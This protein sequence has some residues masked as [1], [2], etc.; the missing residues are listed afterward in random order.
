MKKKFKYLFFG[1]LL[2]LFIPKVYAFTYDIN[3]TTKNTSV[4]KGSVSEIKV[5]LDN[6]KGDNKGIVVCE[7]KISFNGDIALDSKVRTLNSWTMTAGKKYLFET[8]DFV[9]DNSDMFVIPVKVNGNGS[10]K[11]F[12]IACSDAVVEAK[13]DDN[14]MEFTVLSENNNTTGNN[15]ASNNNGTTGN[16]ENNNK[17]EETKSSNANLSNITLNEGIIE[18]DPN[19]TEYEIEVKDFSKLEVTPVAESDKA[20]IMVDKN[21]LENSNSIVLTVTAENGD[22]KV[23]TIRVK[24]VS[25]TVNSNNDNTTNDSKDNKYIP[26]FIVIICILVIINIIRIVLRKKKTI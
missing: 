20:Q 2:I 16:K 18:F 11:I 26:I 5:S 14:E 12:D 17:V 1:I 21:I 4:K 25:S 24:E 3:M 9:F 22:T 23:Y 6:I 15:G 7:M 10:V 13:A 19:V 8:G